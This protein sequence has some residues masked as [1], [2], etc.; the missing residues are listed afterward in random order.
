[1][2]GNQV[3]FPT[4]A[5]DNL[6]LESTRAELTDDER[7][8]IDINNDLSIDIYKKL[9]K[10]DGWGTTNF[11]FSSLAA[12]TSLSLDCCGL[13]DAGVAALCAALPGLQSLELSQNN[14]LTDA[15][16]AAIA[17]TQRQLTRLRLK[18]HAG[19]SVELLPV[20]WPSL[21]PP[22]QSR[23][24]SASALRRCWWRQS[25]L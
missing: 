21:L 25:G 22:P 2:S 7:S 19:R 5:E 18:P 12:L 16:L 4:L 1:M 17:S 15:S 9:L 8:F 3:H 23:R 10:K 14:E 6:G 24:G 20:G 11:V 13:E